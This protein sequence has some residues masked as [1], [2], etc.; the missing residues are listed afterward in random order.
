MNSQQSDSQSIEALS[1]YL[2]YRMAPRK[3]PTQT[4]VHCNV[5]ICLWYSGTAGSSAVIFST[6][7]KDSPLAWMLGGASSSEFPIDILLSVLL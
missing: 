2:P 4:K 6:S 1:R 5:L 3:R 7:L